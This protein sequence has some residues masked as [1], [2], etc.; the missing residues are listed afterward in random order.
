MELRNPGFLRPVSL[1]F[2]PKYEALSYTWGVSKK[3][4]TI[5]V[6]AEHRVAVTDNLFLA[7]QRLR[8]RYFKRAHWVDAICINQSNNE[9][10][11]QQVA[12]MA[13]IYRQAT[14]INVWLGEPGPVKSFGVKKLCDW[15]ASQ[16]LYS[17]QRVGSCYKR[18]SPGV[19]SEIIPKPLTGQ[20]PA[21]HHAGTTA[22]GSFRNLCLRGR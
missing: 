19:C 1:D 4:R 17:E 5:R 2:E 10:R 21:V 11:S 13:R 18:A 14:C 16:I 9:E 12:M 22:L 20:S 3:G 15:M 7:L 6:N 8:R